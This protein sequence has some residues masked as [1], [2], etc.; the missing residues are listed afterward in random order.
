MERKK[1]G[2]STIYSLIAWIIILLLSVNLIMEGVK[3]YLVDYS[4]E[5]KK[6]SLIIDVVN[7]YTKKNI[8]I[9]KIIDQE[10]EEPW[11]NNYISELFPILNVAKES[12]DE[13]PMEYPLVVDEGDIWDNMWNVD[14]DSIDSDYMD[15]N[16][17]DSNSTESNTLESPVTDSSEF[18]TNPMEIHN[19]TLTYKE[20]PM[21]F[22]NYTE[23]KVN[24]EKPI[25][26]EQN[27]NPVNNNYY[28]QLIYHQIDGI[29][30]KNNNMIMEMRNDNIY[31]GTGGVLATSGVP[32]NIQVDIIPGDVFLEHDYHLTSEIL[33][34]AITSKSPE[35]FTV[36]QLKN[37]QFLYNNFYIKAPITTLVDKV[38]DVDYMINK[39]LTLQAKNDKPQIL[40]Y[41]SH[42]Q[43]TFIDSRPGKV[44]DSIV[45]VGQ[46]LAQLLT[47]YGYN[48]IHDDTE[49]DMATGQLDRNLAYD[50]SAV[51]VN[52]ILEENPS[53][54][55]IIDV[56]RDGNNKS[57][58]RVTT[59]N[60]KETA[61]IMLLNG[62][63]RN[64]S[65][66][67]SY[68]PNPNLK[69]NLSFSFQLQLKGRE[70]LPGLMFKNYL[71]AY[72]YNLHLREKAIL[73]EVGTNYNT[74]E[75]LMNS[76]EYFSILLNEILIGN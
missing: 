65:G 72:R 55:V 48:V 68:L 26:L 61:Q 75:E 8:P 51:G 21:A 67:I 5:S 69:D 9:L 36:E 18:E 24:I 59:I 50:Y 28:I 71:H 22:Y 11:V 66:E 4:T 27:K 70:I 58:K 47:G 2:I 39:D 52:K 76:M 33:E 12:G 20:R 14:S 49:Y 19:G 63:S 1:Y 57:M 42:S 40:I 25:F 43:E 17:M 54:E 16:I 44:E 46:Y 35:H 38:F 34:N 32:G 6:E 56:H 29:E 13:T 7:G 37:H 3:L 60:G 64:T 10:E 73:A 30:Y 41:H 62:L 74:V 31:L 45:G 23:Q 53:I 15:E